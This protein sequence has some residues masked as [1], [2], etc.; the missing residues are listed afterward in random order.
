MTALNH[1][2][3]LEIGRRAALACLL[4]LVCFSCTPTENT[5]APGGPPDVARDTTASAD[6]IGDTSVD[7]ASA[8]VSIDTSRDAS[9]DASAADADTRDAA[10]DLSVDA[11]DAADAAD[12]SIDDV[13][14]DAVDGVTIDA[15][16][17]DQFTTTDGPDADGKPRAPTCTVDQP[18]VNGD[19]IGSSCDESW[20]C[21]GHLAPHPC[22]FETIPYCGCDGKT[23]FF[24]LTCPEVPYE[25][26]GACG[27]GVNCDPNDIRCKQPEPDC[28][29]GR[30]ASVVAGCYGA[31]VP[32]TQ[33]RCL[34][35]FECPKRDLYTCMPDLRCDFEMK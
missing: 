28:G 1:C 12:R 26:A 2:T 25:H 7:D 4:S 34:L 11:R 31:C 14:G 6:R 3:R 24:P 30:V 35:A 23:Y 27:D 22:P 5:P 10:F 8:D 29:P 21:F 16:T 15:V 20:E 9:A 32:I 19:C 17:P 13:D 33:C 18:C